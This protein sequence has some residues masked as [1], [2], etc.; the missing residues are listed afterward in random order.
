MKK[1]KRNF[2]VSL[3][4]LLFLASVGCA[5]IDSKP[6]IKNPQI[7]EPNLPPSH[8]ITGI[9]WFRQGRKECGPTSLAMVV[10]YYGKKVTKDEVARW[11]MTAGKMG[12]EVEQLEYY[13]GQQ[14]FRTYR[15]YD[16]TKDK[17]SM[18][19]LIA[20]GYPLI[21]IG[22]IPQNWHSKWAPLW[23]GHYVVVVGYDDVTKNFIIQDP[24]WGKK[25]YEM[26][27]VPYEVFADF[28]THSQFPQLVLCISPK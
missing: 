19:Y 23:E 7:S 13:A 3:T 5:T 28:H 20:Q 8:L 18:K 16:R 27:K 11:V 15:F 22:R 14:G 21:A 2:W 4:E 10:G 9:P 26:T 25:G 6:P 1:M 24:A 12:T 17:S